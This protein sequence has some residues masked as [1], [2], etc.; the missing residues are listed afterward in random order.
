MHLSS[1]DAVRYETAICALWQ[2]GVMVLY[3]ERS[4][5]DAVSQCLC[6]AWNSHS[7]GLRKSGDKG[8]GR[9][10]TSAAG[11]RLPRR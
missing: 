8:D 11:N 2:T 10:Q 7:F 4:F 5:T 9:Q 6:R 1:S 3:S